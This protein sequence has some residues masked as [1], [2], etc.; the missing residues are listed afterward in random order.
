[1]TTHSKETIDAIYE[2]YIVQGLYASQVAKRLGLG[3]RH[4]IISLAWRQKWRR[5][6]EIQK[7]NVIAGARANNQRQKAERRVTKPKPAP[8][9]KPVTAPVYATAPIPFES[10]HPSQC[11]WP[12]NDGAPWMVCGA[13]IERGSYCGPHCARAFDP[14]PLR[15]AERLARVG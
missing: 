4:I 11:A 13:P 3:S 8:K 2:L 7:Q 9:P 6:P 5:S 12:L 1:M 14:R 10:R 15:S